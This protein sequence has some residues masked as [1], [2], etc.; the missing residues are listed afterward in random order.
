MFS[1]IKKTLSFLLICFKYNYSNQNIYPVIGDFFPY[2]LEDFCSKQEI[3]AQKEH[4]GCFPKFKPYFLEELK[5]DPSPK[6]YAGCQF[7]VSMVERLIRYK[8]FENLEKVHSEKNWT[9]DVKN[10]QF[11]PI[12]VYNIL[13]ILRMV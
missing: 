9:R 10:C 2:S 3:K 11:V 4:D 7:H 6:F 1:F 5:G 13:K 12:Q 8:F